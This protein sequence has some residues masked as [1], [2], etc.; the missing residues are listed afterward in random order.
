MNNKIIK[1]LLVGF[2]CISLPAMATLPTFTTGG[3]APGS[4][5][6][7]KTVYDTNLDNVVDT[8]ASISGTGNLDVG[9]YA[10]F[11]GSAPVE[12][13]GGLV[14]GETLGPELVTLDATC[15]GWTASQWM[16]RSS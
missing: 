5:D 3:G 8:A 2:M 14:V 15:T 12:A 10:H 6:M 9:G 16:A 7:T 11:N 1:A 13:D 4:G